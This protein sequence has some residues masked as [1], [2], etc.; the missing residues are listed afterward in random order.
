MAEFVAHFD[1]A[2]EQAWI[3]EYDGR[4]AGSIF[5]MRGAEPTAA[6]LRLLYVEPGAR[7]L[8]I[9]AGLVAACI[10]QARMFGYRQL[11]LWTNDV[12][13]SASRIYEA[14]GFRLIAEESHR[15]FGHELVGQTWTL[16]L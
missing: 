4:I 11:S 1:A 14:A 2:R 9:G 6:R 8:G 13:V 7:G 16:E 15:S 12:L 3:A 10:A 5:L